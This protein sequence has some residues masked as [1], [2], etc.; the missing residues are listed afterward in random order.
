MISAMSEDKAKQ[1]A[2]EA[3][4]A[5]GKVTGR[6]LTDMNFQGKNS[7]MNRES[8]INKALALTQKKSLNVTGLSRAGK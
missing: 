5:G 7:T 1:K 4:H 6:D 8:T 2:D 3:A